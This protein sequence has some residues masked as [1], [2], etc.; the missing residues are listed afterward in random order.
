M[1]TR[2]RIEVI[3]LGMAVTPHARSL[4][5]LAERV[6]VAGAH[7]RSAARRDSFAQRFLPVTD[8]LVAILE[9]SSV[10][11]VMIL[12]PPDTHLDLVRRCAAAGKHIL[13]EKPLEITTARAEQLV[14]AC[15]EAGVTL[16]LV[17][18]H[19]FRPAAVQFAAL[20]RRG[21]SATSSPPPPA[22]ASGARNPI[23]TSLAA[24]RWRAMAAAC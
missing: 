1:S 4:L 6:E 17:L 5:D 23:T 10:D 11:C 12:T 20:Q 14:A 19:R 3:G 2:H 7:A 22:S 8:Q 18:Q 21:R 15:R 24:A 16:G 13:L 9:D